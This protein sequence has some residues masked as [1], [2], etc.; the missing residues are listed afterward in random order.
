MQMAQATDFYFVDLTLP[1]FTIMQTGN[2]GAVHHTT[3]LKTELPV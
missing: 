3:I 2:F 1:I